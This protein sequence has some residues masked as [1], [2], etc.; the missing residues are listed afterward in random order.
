MLLDVK[1]RE[2]G[3][4]HGK[5]EKAGQ[6]RPDPARPPRRSHLEGPFR[7]GPGNLEEKKTILLQFVTKLLQK[8]LVRRPPP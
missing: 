4:G 8:N 2:E 7:K 1:S 6:A 5:E 3:A